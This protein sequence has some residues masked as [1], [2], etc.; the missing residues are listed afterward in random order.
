MW[1]QVPIFPLDVDPLGIIDIVGAIL[2]LHCNRENRLV[3]PLVT[4]VIGAAVPLEFVAGADVVFDASPG[5]T[6]P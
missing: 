2:Y 5:K 6:S 4:G 3:A 1:S